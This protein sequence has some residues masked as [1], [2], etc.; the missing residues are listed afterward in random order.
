MFWLLCIQKTQ[1]LRQTES[2]LHRRQAEHTA[3]LVAKDTAQQHADEAEAKV[4]IEQGLLSSPASHQ[5]R[6]WETTTAAESTTK[7]NCC[8]Q[9]N[10]PCCLRGTQFFLQNN[11]LRQT[12]ATFQTYAYKNESSLK[13]F[14]IQP[15]ALPTMTGLKS[16]VIHDLSTYNSR[17]A[18]FSP[19]VWLA[20][21]LYG[22]S[23]VIVVKTKGMTKVWQTGINKD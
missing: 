23:V 22:I 18:V 4:C 5:M 6:M 9:E 7:N 2:T 1:Q 11:K 13:V 8:N 14:L 20:I 21:L 19:E 16:C 3:I 10:W 17:R 12:T 15:N